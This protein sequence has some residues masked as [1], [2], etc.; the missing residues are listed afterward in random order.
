MPQPLLV[1]CALPTLALRLW[2]LQVALV[3]DMTSQPC[4]FAFGTP[5]EV[6]PWPPLPASARMQY[7]TAFALV[8]TAAAESPVAPFLFAVAVPR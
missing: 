8:A 4:R 7:E 1:E 3:F 6:M 2:P 5:L